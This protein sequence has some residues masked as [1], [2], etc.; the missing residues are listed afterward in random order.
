MPQLLPF[1]Q[2]YHPAPGITERLPVTRD[3]IRALQP[4][5]FLRTQGPRF[6]RLSI[7]NGESGRSV[8]AVCGLLPAT[9]FHDG[10]VLPHERTL[11]A[12]LER[13]QRLVSGDRGALGK[14]IL[15]TTPSLAEFALPDPDGEVDPVIFY[16]HQHIYRLAALPLSSPQGLALPTPLVIADGH[17]RAYTHAALAADGLAEFQFIPVVVAGADQLTI[18]TFQRLID[19]EGASAESLLEKLKPHFRV[20]PLAQPRQ[21]AR[22]GDWLY[23]Y[24]N[25]HYHLERLDKAI[26]DTDPG[27]LN[28]VVLPDLFGI[29]DTRT[30]PRIESI[31]P[32]AVVSGEVFFDPAHHGYVKFLGKPITR[33]HFFAEVQEGRTLPPKSTRFE[34]RVPSGLLV[35][36]P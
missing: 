17:H 16:G 24:R 15:L 18:G 23:S 7:R 11:S 5:P 22:R 19:S 1:P 27:W 14:P 32:P 33:E 8:N 6:A 4:F 34:P 20:Q 13:Q 35:W 36:I 28:R 10:S 31:D 21:V 29:T 2:Y 3:G 26:T 30:D 25:E 9:A 12:R